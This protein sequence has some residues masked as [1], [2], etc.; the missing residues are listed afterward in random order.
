MS[1]MIVSLE[2]NSRE[3]QLHRPLM[4]NACVN[5]DKLSKS[6]VFVFAEPKISCLKDIF[7]VTHSFISSD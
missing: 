3:V 6:C 7:V 4:M 1:G 2:G 5:E